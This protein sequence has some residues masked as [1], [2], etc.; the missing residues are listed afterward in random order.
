MSY[1]KQRNFFLSALVR[2]EMTWLQDMTGIATVFFLRGL[3]IALI[4]N[5]CL[6]DEV[7]M[8]SPETC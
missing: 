8:W 2:G 4:L 7:I 3:M 5:F 1:Q 6:G